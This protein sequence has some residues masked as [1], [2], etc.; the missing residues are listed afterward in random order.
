MTRRWHLNGKFKLFVVS[1][2]FIL[3]RAQICSIFNT[4]NKQKEIST[5]K[6]AGSSFELV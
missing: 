1:H 2:S 6:F 4:K 3:K 5:G